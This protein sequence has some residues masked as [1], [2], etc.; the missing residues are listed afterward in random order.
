MKYVLLCLT[1]ITVSVCFAQNLEKDTIQLHEVLVKNVKKPKLKTIRIGS[2][3]NTGM[4]MYNYSQNVFPYY[5]IENIPHGVIKEI[6]FFFMDV[7]VSKEIDKRL[8]EKY[9][10]TI[11]E[12]DL[13]LFSITDDNTI[14]AA[15]NN[16]PI[17]VVLEES[18]ND[19]VRKITIDVSSYAISDTRF[20]IQLK[21]ST[22]QPCDECYFYLPLIVSGSKNFCFL[23][24]KDDVH[25]TERQADNTGPAGGLYIELKSL[26]CDY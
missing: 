12:F 1:L 23:G 7:R 13:Y 3:D 16:K 6:T 21:K 11:T 9:T 5:L 25:I 10:V 4:D 26:T 19:G 20:F 17:P 14:G 22:P 8:F 15:I 2:L 24:G 18:H